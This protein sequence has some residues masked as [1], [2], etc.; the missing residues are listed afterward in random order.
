MSAMK[1]NVLKVNLLA[2]RHPN[3]ISVP[4]RMADNSQEKRY[5]NFLEVLCHKNFQ[6]SVHTAFFKAIQEPP[7]VSERQGTTNQNKEK[8]VA[9][10][11]ILRNQI[12]E[13]YMLQGWVANWTVFYWNDLFFSAFQPIGR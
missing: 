2:N 13:Y 8:G 11:Q 3:S 5:S 4:L 12:L 10:K 1:V 7:R 6:L 9:T